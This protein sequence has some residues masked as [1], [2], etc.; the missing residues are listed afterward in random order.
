M[1][2]IQKNTQEWW[3]EENRLADILRQWHLDRENRDLATQVQESMERLGLI[4][5]SETTDEDQ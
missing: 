4:V 3:A 2:K 1:K 5:P